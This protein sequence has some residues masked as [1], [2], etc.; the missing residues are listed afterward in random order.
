MHELTRA[1]VLVIALGLVVGPET[2]D[3]M[4]RAAAGPAVSV[5][6]GRETAPPAPTPTPTPARVDFA[7]QIQPILETRCAPCHFAGGKMYERLPFDRPAT[8]RTLG[9]KLFTRIKDEDERRL[10]REFLTQPSEPDHEP[11]RP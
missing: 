10:I 11:Q 6:N 1:C 5:A 7:T 8:I 2:C 3:R 9:T 4:K